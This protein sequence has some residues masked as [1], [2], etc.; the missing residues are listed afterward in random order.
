M[1]NHL[2]VPARLSEIESEA[3]A[4]ARTD[5]IVWARQGAVHVGR[6]ELSKALRCFQRSL[7]SY[8]DCVDAWTGLARV[9][10][11]IR[12]GRRAE[13]CLDVA[14]RVT[15]RELRKAIA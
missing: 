7:E 12:D 3:S 13:A 4:D 15:R 5:A 9:F 6:G 14:R 11:Q 8:I 2:R 10:V 1:L